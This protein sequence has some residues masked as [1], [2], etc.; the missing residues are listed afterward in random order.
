MAWVEKSPS[1]R[2]PV[3]FSFEIF[4]EA[5]LDSFRQ[6]HILE[7]FLSFSFRFFFEN[8]FGTRNILKI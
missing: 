3:E 6:L 1:I 5:T 4:L 2:T 8:L 7:I